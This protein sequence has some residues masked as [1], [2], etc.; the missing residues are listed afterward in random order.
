MGG[1]VAAELVS[2]LAELGLIDR[3]T[4]D[5]GLVACAPLDRDVGDLHHSA[6]AADD[7]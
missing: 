1:A 4:G 5:L 7:E 2:E 3:E 6:L